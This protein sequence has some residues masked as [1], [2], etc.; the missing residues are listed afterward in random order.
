[1]TMVAGKWQQPRKQRP[2]QWKK[3]Q[4][5]GGSDTV[6][7]VGG[8]IGTTMTAMTGNEDYNTGRASRR[9]RRWQLVRQLQ[10]Q[11]QRRQLLRQRKS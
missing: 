8:N 7:G 11:Q 4:L 5:S 9:C 6:N 2:H 1:M 10:S 3:Q